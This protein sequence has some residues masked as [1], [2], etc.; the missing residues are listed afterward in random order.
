VRCITL[1]TV[2]TDASAA[3][4]TSFVVD[5]MSRFRVNDFTILAKGT[6]GVKKSIARRKVHVYRGPAMSTIARDQATTGPDV[7]HAVRAFD[8]EICDR[9]LAVRVTPVVLQANRAAH[10]PSRLE[11]LG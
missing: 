10:G 6:A 5:V 4:A 9:A 3:V 11:E 7:A 8:L 1:D 2:A